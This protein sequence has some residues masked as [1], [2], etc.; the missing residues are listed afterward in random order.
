VDRAAPSVEDA[1]ALAAQAHQGQRYPSPES[2]PCIFHPLRIMLSF[3][4]PVDQMA[5]ALHDSVEDTDLELHDLVD[6]DYP[7]ELVAAIDSLTHRAGE[8]YEDY[9][10]RVAA[11]EV[12]RRV[13]ITDLRENLAN[14]RRSPEAPG[15]AERIA[16]YDV[17]LA[18]LGAPH[19]DPSASFPAPVQPVS[20]IAGSVSVRRDR[21][22]RTVGLG[23]LEW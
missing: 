16:R 23:R 6:A 4:D 1:I 14:N 10:E 3:L 22:V 15:N 12:A 7:A 18:R 20:L 11:N 21:L 13:K 8:S 9:I 2:E 17:A 19:R 5:A